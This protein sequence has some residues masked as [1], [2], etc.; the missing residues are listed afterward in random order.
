MHRVLAIINN[1]I[2]NILPP[3]VASVPGVVRWL[4]GN[5]GPVFTTGVDDPGK[6]SQPIGNNNAS[7]AEY[8]NPVN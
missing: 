7:G 1:L 6:T 5:D 8:W 2:G 3:S 4:G